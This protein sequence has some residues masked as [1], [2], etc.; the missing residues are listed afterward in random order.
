MN[1]S[2][3]QDTA[4]VVTQNNNANPPARLHATA[5]AHGRRLAIASRPQATAIGVCER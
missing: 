1:D 5:G 3:S 4:Q 2:G